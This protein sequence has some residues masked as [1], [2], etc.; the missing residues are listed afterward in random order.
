MSCSVCEDGAAC[1]VLSC[2][3][4]VP[5]LPISHP[6]DCV[7]TCTPTV[8]IPLIQQTNKQ[9]PNT[10][11]QH[12]GEPYGKAGS[13]GIQGAA[14]SFVSGISGC[15]FNVVGFPI[16][17]FS[18]QVRRCVSKWKGECHGCRLGFVGLFV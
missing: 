4:Q 16:H 12:P 3:A 7:L 5:I 10:P 11:Q 15:Y 6:I 8:S 1:S 13:Y 17:A 18:K 2:M 9:S 14:S